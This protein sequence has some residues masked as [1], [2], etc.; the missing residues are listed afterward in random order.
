LDAEVESVEETPEQTYLHG[1]AND[2][3]AARLRAVL[4]HE[5]G[6]A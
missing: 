2:S 4:L 6:R 1:A 3:A 5:M